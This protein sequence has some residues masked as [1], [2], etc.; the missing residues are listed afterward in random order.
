MNEIFAK[1]IYLNKELHDDVKKAAN[2][3]FDG[4]SYVKNLWILNTYKKRGGKV[5]YEGKRPSKDQIKK[6]VDKKVK[7]LR[8]EASLIVDMSEVA[9]S[10]IYERESILAE[11][12]LEDDEILDLMCDLDYLKE[13]NFEDFAEYCEDAYL[14]EAADNSDK[15]S[16]VY[17]KYHQ[18][19][20]MGYNALKSWAENPCSKVASLSRGPINRNL[21][22]LSKSKEQWTMA[23]VRSANR[24]IS[25]VSRMK[26]AEQGEKTKTRDGKSCPSKRDIS[27]KNWAY[28]P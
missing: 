8:S 16:E 23:D 17:K 10:F 13:T 1:V 5:K 26:G 21:K 25:F 20:N 6:N 28:N 27:L 14:A 19:V 9:V 24:T 7:R 2:Q 11:K 4:E 22:L 3:K 12:H 15:I 18:T